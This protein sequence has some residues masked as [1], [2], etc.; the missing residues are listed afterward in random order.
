ME[1]KRIEE[2]KRDKE[3]IEAEDP[4]MRSIKNIEIIEKKNKYKK[5]K[6]SSQLLLNNPDLNDDINDDNDD[7]IDL[8]NN[9]NNN[10]EINSDIINND[11]DMIIENDNDNISVNSMTKMSNFRKKKLFRPSLALLKQYVMRPDLVEENDCNAPNP[12]L[13]IKMKSIRNT[14][15]VPSH[16]SQK[17]KYLQGKRGYLKTPF[18]LPDYIESTGITKIRDARLD[19]LNDKSLKQ[20]QRERMRPKNT[21]MEINYSILHDAFFK[22]SYKPNMT[23]FGDVY[24]EGKEF[25]K[26]FKKHK[27][28][29]IS[30]ELKKALGLTP[31]YKVISPNGAL[32]QSKKV[33]NETGEVMWNDI[34]TLKYGTYVIWDETIGKKIKINSPVNGWIWLTSKDGKEDILKRVDIED[35]PPW[36]INMQRFGPPPS[37]PDLKIPGLNAPIPPNKMY[38]FHD[39]QWGKPPVD[40]NGQPLYGDPFGIWTEPISKTWTKNNRWG[41]LQT[42]DNNMDTDS[43]SNDS[44]DDSDDDNDTDNDMDMDIDINNI[45]NIDIN[46]MLNNSKK[47]HKINDDNISLSGLL[48]PDNI[49]LR[50]KNQNI[51]DINNSNNINSI[52]N[53]GTDSSISQSSTVSKELYQVLKQKQSNNIRNPNTKFGSNVI[54][55]IP[56]NNN[57]NSNNNSNINPNNNNAYTNDT[58]INM[59]RK[60]EELLQQERDRL[61]GNNVKRQK[62]NDNDDAMQF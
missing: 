50:K 27:P 36:L 44:D 11:D 40:E 7:D 2:E 6:L 46:A 19:I 56:S 16:W 43:D 47:K 25:E 30:D 3:R 5:N 42:F 62:V 51:T 49:S 18:K 12:L 21:G 26:R 8:I 45:N 39:G 58:N 41:I 17:R 20:K 29:Y 10:N 33:D 15:P 13:L 55:D 52:H 22:H 57:N 60:Y 24:Y 23:T 61:N 9:N 38:G 14:V 54:Y 34:T 31:R 1:Q 4:I 37:Y 53:N 48:T 59:K 32:V 35:P 28:G